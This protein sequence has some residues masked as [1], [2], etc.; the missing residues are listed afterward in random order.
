MRKDRKRERKIRKGRERK[1]EE[2]RKTKPGGE[3]VVRR[4]SWSS[5]ESHLL[6]QRVTVL[7]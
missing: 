6:G 3:A 4:S 7:S 5:R 1:R 2:K